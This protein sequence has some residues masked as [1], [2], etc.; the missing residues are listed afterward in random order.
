MRFL[1]AEGGEVLGLPHRDMRSSSSR[2]AAR[3]VQHAIGHKT[4]TTRCYPTPQ[5]REIEIRMHGITIASHLSV[6]PALAVL[7]PK[8]RSLLVGHSFFPNLISGPFRAGLH[9]AFAFAIVACV[10]A[11][12]ASLMRGGRYY[13]AEESRSETHG[14][15]L[16]GRVE[17]THAGG[18]RRPERCA[19]SART[20]REP[21]GH[22]PAETSFPTNLRT[23]CSAP[24]PVPAALAAA[25]ACRLGLAAAVHCGC[26]IGGWGEACELARLYALWRGG[27][28]SHS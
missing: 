15:V 9:E 4:G 7:T 1:P 3:H 27:E 12:A 16:G 17:H 26:A 22:A 25:A 28:P 6:G 11:A 14:A 18:S 2:R 10:V 8:N 23:D 5:E 19:Q 13:D 20:L 24:R 21:P